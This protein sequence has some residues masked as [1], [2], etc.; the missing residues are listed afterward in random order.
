MRPSRANYNVRTTALRGGVLF[1]RLSRAAVSVCD[2][3]Q[4]HY[5]FMR[6]AQRRW[7]MVRESFGA[8]FRLLMRQR[9][10]QQDGLD[11]PAHDRVQIFRGGAGSGARACAASPQRLVELQGVPPRGD[12]RPLDHVLEL[13][14]VTGPRMALQ[15]T[16]ITSAASVIGVLPG[17]RW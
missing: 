11:V 16:F 14:H 13:A 5:N 9:Q 12:H 2:E 3:P 17:S 1:R 4:H 7:W 8:A 15:S 10:A 6:E